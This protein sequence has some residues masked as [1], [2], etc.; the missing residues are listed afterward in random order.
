MP[1]TKIS[2]SE[3]FTDVSITIMKK[4]RDYSHKYVWCYSK[5]PDSSHLDSHFNFL[6]LSF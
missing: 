1:V 5:Q 6:L 3:N 4:P 2:F